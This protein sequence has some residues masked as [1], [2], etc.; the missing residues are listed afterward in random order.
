MH[1]DIRAG[2]AATIEVRSL[3]SILV[4]LILN[5]LNFWWHAIIPKA[6]RLALPS[7]WRGTILILVDELMAGACWV[8]IGLF[9]HFASL[10]TLSELKCVLDLAP[11]E[12]APA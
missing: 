5:S 12:G 2:R 8:G 9:Q 7:L 3:E 4:G 1:Q 11:R 6:M 10:C